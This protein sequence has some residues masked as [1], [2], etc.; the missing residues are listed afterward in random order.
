VLRNYRVKRSNLSAL[1][2]RLLR[3]GRSSPD[4]VLLTV[5]DA[6]RFY[7]VAN[8][9]KIK[10]KFKMQKR[11]ELIRSFLSSTTLYLSLSSP[12]AS[13]KMLISTI[14]FSFLVRYAS[15]H[16]TMFTESMY[17]FDYSAGEPNI[18]IG[19]G[20]EGVSSWWFRGPETRA[21]K[22]KQGNVTELTAGKTLRLEIACHIAFTSFGDKTTDPSD[23]TSACPQNPGAYHA[24]PDTSVV[25][26]SFLSGCTPVQC[27]T[28]SCAARRSPFALLSEQVHWP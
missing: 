17:N 13:F 9:T 24:G 18:P 5:D 26:H 21:A 12:G 10:F 20:L 11:S 16:M 8:A 25:D 22:P 4:P 28:I 1:N 15:A 14:A 3:K 2:N 6:K 27:T 19:P 23:P 7:R